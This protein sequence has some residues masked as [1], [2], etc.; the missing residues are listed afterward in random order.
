[1]SNCE[2]ILEGKKKN[3]ENYS[4]FYATH[5]LACVG[6][7]TACSGS[8]VVPSPMVAKAT[9]FCLRIDLTKP[10][11][12]TGEPSS[13]PLDVFEEVSSVAMVGVDDR[14]DDMCRKKGRLR[15]SVLGSKLRSQSDRA[16]IV[17]PSG[18]TVH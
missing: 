18:T 8:T 7:K 13:P 4:S 10:L 9:F 1:M 5:L 17:L 16:F 6:V 12:V 11:I 3:K 2:T 15:R 14:D